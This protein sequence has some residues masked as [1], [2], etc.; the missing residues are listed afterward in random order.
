MNGQCTVFIGRPLDE[1]IYVKIESGSLD[2]K[3]QSNSHQIWRIIEF[4]GSMQDEQ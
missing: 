4:T 3:L 2:C 1:V